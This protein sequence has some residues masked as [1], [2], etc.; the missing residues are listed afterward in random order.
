MKIF[1]MWLKWYMNLRI[2]DQYFLFNKKLMFQF[3][4]EYI[5]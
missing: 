2:N 4:R 3:K 5:K 1:K